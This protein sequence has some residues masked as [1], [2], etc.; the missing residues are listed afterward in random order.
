MQRLKETKPNAMRRL[1]TGTLK[2]LTIGLWISTAT[3][4]GKTVIVPDSKELIAHPTR[5]DYYCL[6][7]GYLK[8]IMDAYAVCLDK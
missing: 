2:I 7:A 3:C 4:A 8:E 5:D 6:S 1:L